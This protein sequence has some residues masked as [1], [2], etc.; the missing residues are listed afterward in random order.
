MLVK[1][2]NLVKINFVSFKVI[3]IA[4]QI[5]VIENFTHYFMNFDYHFPNYSDLSLQ[6]INYSILPSIYF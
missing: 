6:I 5:T 3:I 2:E 1:I 4:I